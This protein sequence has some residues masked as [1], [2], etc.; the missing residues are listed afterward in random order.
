[1]RVSPLNISRA[2]DLYQSFD[3]TPIG[4]PQKLMSSRG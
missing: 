1:M 4:S 3:M 2:C